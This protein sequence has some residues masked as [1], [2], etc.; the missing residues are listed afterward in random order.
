MRPML[1]TR[2]SSVPTGP[3][4]LHEVK[5]DGMRVLVSVRDGR[6]TLLS[7]N[8]NDVTVSFPELAALADDPAVR[9]HDLLLDGE[10]VA[11]TDGRPVFGALADRMHVKNAVKAEKAAARNPV[12]LM[13]FDLMAL[14]DLDVISLK[15]EDRRA[16]LESL[17]IEGPHWKV[18]PTYDDGLVLLEATKAQGL[19]GIV[20]KRR[21][22]CYSFGQR[23]DD[24]LKFPHRPSG[25]YVV[26]GWRPETGTKNRLGALLVG[27]P[28]PDG[29]V[30]R[31]R[32]GSGVTGKA[33]LKLKDL[34][35]PLTCDEHPFTEKVPREDALGT[36][37]VEPSVV[38]EVASLGMT[39]Q[40]RLRQPSYV[41]V[42]ADVCPED[43]IDLGGGEDG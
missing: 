29:L 13:V 42:R 3:G 4:W 26:G 27:E 10:I 37:W 38:V 20:S 17:G 23:S 8:E 22:S 43:L 1:A 30:F 11:F 33:A 19:E 14:D 5:W 31:G 28:T 12:T 9:G 35:D 41:G 32:V 15:L 34:L 24:W 39:P 18:P 40:A 6:V 36:V 7:R 16:A 21:S 25:S 2:G